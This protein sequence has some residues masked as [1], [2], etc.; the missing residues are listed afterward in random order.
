MIHYIV[1]DHERN[2]R[3]SSKKQ[4]LDRE[5]EQRE[6]QLR[7]HAQREK[8]QQEQEQ[9]QALPQ[10]EHYQHTD[11]IPD[12]QARSDIRSKSKPQD[13]REFVLKD[14]SP[15]PP[16]AAEYLARFPMLLHRN[17]YVLQHHCMSKLPDLITSSDRSGLRN[18]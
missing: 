14:Y 4:R 5:R 6:Q 15:T 7:L 10:L 11:D 13:Q 18:C 9:E 17:H 16:R 2:A 3:A 8:H 1:N 12:S